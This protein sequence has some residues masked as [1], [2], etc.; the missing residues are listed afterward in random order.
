[1]YE[2]LPMCNVFVLLPVTCTI[3][4]IKFKNLFILLRMF[5]LE[6]HKTSIESVKLLPFKSDYPAI[7]ACSDRNGS[8]Q[9]SDFKPL[10]RKRKFGPY[11]K[12]ILWI[13]MKHGQ[14]DLLT[15]SQ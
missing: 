11:Y 12:S 13:D 6:H 8:V 2:I 3:R 15:S 1:M 10:K 14:L 5:Y 9:K 7:R 4:D